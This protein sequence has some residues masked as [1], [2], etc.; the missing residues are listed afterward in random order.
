MPSALRTSSAKA[1]SHSLRILIGYTFSSRSV[2]QI[3]IEASVLAFLEATCSIKTLLAQL[4]LIL[5]LTGPKG[6]QCCSSS[7]ECSGFGNLAAGVC[8]KGCH[9]DFT[10]K[11]F[12]LLV[13]GSSRLRLAISGTLRNISLDCQ[14]EVV[15]DGSWVAAS[16]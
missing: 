14:L 3:L 15:G 6:L 12:S 8:S 7:A 5:V 1:A 13:T 4:L 9:G 16:A 11:Q 10:G 2:G